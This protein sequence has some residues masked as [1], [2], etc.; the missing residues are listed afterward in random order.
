[1]ESVVETEEYESTLEKYEY[2]CELI[3]G[4]NRQVKPYFDADPVA[5]TL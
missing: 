2:P 1:M 5:L 3:A 4:L